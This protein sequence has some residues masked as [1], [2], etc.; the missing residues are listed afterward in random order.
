LGGFTSG[1]PFRRKKGDLT[2]GWDA[3]DAGKLLVGSSVK[4]KLEKNAAKCD[5][6]K[7]GCFRL[8]VISQYVGGFPFYKG[9]VGSVFRPTQLL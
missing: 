6:I 4:V 9:D 7:K 8:S 1:Y 2:L 3:F 5:M